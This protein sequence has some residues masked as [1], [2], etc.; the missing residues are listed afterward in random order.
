MTLFLRRFVLC[1][2]LATAWL[3]CG[4]AQGHELGTIRTYATFARDGT[5]RIEV[6]VDREHLPPGF[7]ARVDA[8]R[9][10]I[11]G[12]TEPVAHERV[13]Q[14]LIEVLNH[15]RVRF[16]GRSVAIRAAW[17][18]PDPAA[19]EPVLLLSGTIPGGVA[20]F[21]WTNDLKLGSYLLT[22]RTEGDETPSRQWVEGG[23]ESKPFLLTSQVVPPTR[24]QV[25]RQYLAL[26]FTH[27]LPKGTDHILFV[28]GIFLLSV[29]LKPV[30]LQVTAFTV[31]HTGWGKSFVDELTRKRQAPGRRR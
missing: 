21:T 20:S 19:A 14:I 1:L 26:G 6:F 12:L 25:A 8:P 29:R 13:G 23:E 15:S 24:A 30:L 2:A 7:A 27:I 5:F 16:D 28:L 9:I 17:D 18:Q 4:A 3:A 11:A 10:P 31:A 22:I